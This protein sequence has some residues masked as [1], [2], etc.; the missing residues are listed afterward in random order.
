MVLSPKG[1]QFLQGSLTLDTIN[2]ILVFL[3]VGWMGWVFATSHHLPSSTQLPPP[4]SSQVEK[5]AGD[6]VGD[7]AIGLLKGAA[8][9]HTAIA[10]VIFF[11]RRGDKVGVV[12]QLAVPPNNNP[13]KC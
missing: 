8:R 5:S 12:C 13:E 3:F 6:D 4:M 2:T 11:W 7:A 10:L 1:S 9:V